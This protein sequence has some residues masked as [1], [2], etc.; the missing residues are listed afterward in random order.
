MRDFTNILETEVLPTLKEQSG[1]F[2]EIQGSARR[3]FDSFQ[4]LQSGLTRAEGTSEQRCRDS[5][6][7]HEGR[8]KQLEDDI[9]SM[10]R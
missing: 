4:D 1:I 9:A 6:A 5:V 8:I 3:L 10:I 2:V 7:E